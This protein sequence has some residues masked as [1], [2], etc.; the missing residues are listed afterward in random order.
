MRVRSVS[1]ALIATFWLLW[2]D[3]VHADPVTEATERV[4]GVEPDEGPAKA[5]A[6]PATPAANTEAAAGV[7]AASA[8]SAAPSAKASRPKLHVAFAGGIALSVAFV[9]WPRPTASGARDGDLRFSVLRIG[10]RAS[11]GGFRLD[12]EYRIYPFY[13]FLRHGFV[14]YDFNE[15]LS[16]D[17][18]VS[19]VP[20][21]LL[22]FA[23]N[24][25]FF[26]LPYYV[27]LEDDADFGMRVH[28]QPGAWD[29]WLAFYKNSEGSYFGHSRDSARFSYDAVQASAEELTGSGISAERNDRETNTGVARVAYTWRAQDFSLELGGSGRVGTLEDLAT[30]GRSVNW[31][32]SPH[33]LLSYHRVEL[34]LEGIIYRFTPHAQEG[35]DRRLVAMGAFDAPYAVASRGYLLVANLAWSHDL[36]WGPIELVRIYA[37]TGQL[38]KSASSFRTTRQLV[39]GGYLLAG[40]V[41]LSVDA[42]LGKH[43]PW[44]GPDYAAAL[45]AG[46]ASSRWHRWINVNVGFAY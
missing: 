39:L 6:P 43:H 24:S 19:R 35:D 36:T 15:K 27:G 9:D 16:V 7:P 5:P 12:F 14:A 40:P 17:I 18:G 37:D 32:A 45:G 34:G 33:A 1:L 8:T 2:P 44:V 41:H 30:H 10:A 42:A 20:F 3:P 38:W 29:L 31:A 13:Q 28:Y 46:G 11:Y 23:S 21:G 25:W 4:T 22:P 26:G